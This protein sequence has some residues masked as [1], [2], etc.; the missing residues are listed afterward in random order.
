MFGTQEHTA[1]KLS[2]IWKNRKWLNISCKFL[3][4][5]NSLQM[6]SNSNIWSTSEAPV[7]SIRGPSTMRVRAGTTISF[8]CLAEGHPTPNITWTK[9]LSLRYIGIGIIIKTIDKYLAQF[10]S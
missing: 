1:V 2:Q 5:T 3:V 10:L 8:A 7:V 6:I 4:N 9:D